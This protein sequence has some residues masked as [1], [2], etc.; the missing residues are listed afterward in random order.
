[1]YETQSYKATKADLSQQV[2]EPK[3][4]S[5]QNTASKYFRRGGAMGRCHGEENQNESEA[6]CAMKLGAG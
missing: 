6:F 5:T 1:M 2:N 3:S 4:Q